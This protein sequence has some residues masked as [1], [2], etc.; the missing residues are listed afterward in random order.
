MN[1]ASRA[2]NKISIIY[3]I[4]VSEKEDKECR[5]ANLFEEVIIKNFLHLAKDIDLQISKS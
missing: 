4:H 2:H 1:R 3:T 5:T